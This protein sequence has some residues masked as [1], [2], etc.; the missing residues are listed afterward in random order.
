MALNE[1]KNL[2]IKELREIFSAEMQVVEAFPTFIAAA[3]SEELVEAFT[4]YLN[5]TKEEVE[6]LNK[7]FY[8]LQVDRGGERCESMEGLIRECHKVIER[9]PKSP[10]RDVALIMR[11]QCIE[12]FAIAV[13]GSLRTFAKQIEMHEEANLFQRTLNEKGQQNRNL[14][15]IA[16]GGFFTSGLNLL[17]VS[18]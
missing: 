17:A 8:I 6:R 18:R 5:Q 13:Y 1:F 16:E 12:H 4:A 9:Y 14:T 3:E 15:S 2:F 11:F 10:V 7:I